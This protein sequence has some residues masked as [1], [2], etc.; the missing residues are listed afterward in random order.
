MHAILARLTV[1]VFV[2]TIVRVAAA[3]DTTTRLRAYGKH[4]MEECKSCHRERGPNAGVAPIEDWDRE[5][6][7]QI[8]RDYQSGIRSNPAMASVAKSLSEEQ[9][10]ALA[11]Y[12]ASLQ[13]RS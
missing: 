3:D 6:F 10:Q 5:H 13:K 2:G 1:A 11:V 12:L 4:L 9:L 7:I 8:M